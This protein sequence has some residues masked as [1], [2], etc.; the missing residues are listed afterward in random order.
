AECYTRCYG[1]WDDTVRIVKLEHRRAG[2]ELALEGEVPREDYEVLMRSFRARNAVAHGFKPEEGAELEELVR[3]LLRA[4][5]RL[6]RLLPDTQ[7]A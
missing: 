4:T 2:R 7:P 1:S 5:A 3:K 6:I